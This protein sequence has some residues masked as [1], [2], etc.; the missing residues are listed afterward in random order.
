MD[1]EIRFLPDGRIGPRGAA[2]YI[3]VQPHTLAQ[4]RSLGKGPAFLKPCGRVWYLR[5]DL[6][7]WLE[8]SRSTSTGQARLR[9]QLAGARIKA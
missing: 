8:R 2:A 9:A 1:T 4:W 5:Q 6:D 7:T 3:G